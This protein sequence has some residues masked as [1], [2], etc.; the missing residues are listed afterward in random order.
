MLHYLERLSAFVARTKFEDLGEPAVVATQNV[1]MDT[2]GAMIAGSQLP[3][4]TN[5]AQFAVSVSG[6]GK[7]T[8]LGHV[9]QV[10]PM[11]AAMV[12]ATA[13]V[14]LEMDEGNRFGGGHP[15]IHVVPGA[16]AMA[17]E[18]GEGGKKLVESVLTGY[19]ACS[20]I[21]GAT[22]TRPNVH[23]HGTWGT[24]GTTVAVAKL[25]G[26]DQRHIREVI[27][28]SSSMS[29][30][31]SWTP[32]FEG[33]TIR[34]LYPG[35]SGFQGILAVHLHQ[36]GYSALKDGPSD[37]Y[38]TILGEGF[39]SED[40]VSGLEEGKAYRIQQN[41]FKM[42]ACCLF[43]HPALDTIVSLVER[44]GF[45]AEDVEWI[46]VT[47]IPFATRMIQGYPENMLSAKFHMPYAI[48]VLMVRG[49]ADITSFY[50][51][52]I[53]DP[54]IRELARKVEVNTDPDMNMKR[55]DYPS[56]RLSIGLKNGRIFS[57]ST[58]VIR[59]DAANPVSQEELVDKFM[60]LTADVLGHERALEA[61]EAISH[62]E[63]LM[64]V[65]ELT[66]LLGSE[67]GLGR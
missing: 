17:E 28:L 6:N 37:I 62:L 23:S 20:R 63:R 48:A 46:K 33:A 25:L 65:R 61:V 13:G 16:L 53:D 4:N 57:G 7:A 27:N 32:C 47:T 9:S 42:H 3:E 54:R 14:A 50:P 29:P 11:F 30:A 35:S 5:F 56:A 31:N 44:E 40:A 15:G 43:I 24:I 52:S 67:R 49:K 41:Y 60:F 22:A 2:I 21:G 10:Q 34:N 18:L 51:D 55:A 58:T 12:N 26:F 45:G 64:D 39:A 1:I 66:S 8:L 19:E 38:G 59:G 36:C